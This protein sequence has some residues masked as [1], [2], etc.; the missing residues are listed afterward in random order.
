MIDKIDI[1]FRDENDGFNLVS[2]YDD[3]LEAHPNDPTAR[4]VQYEVAHQ[5]FFDFTPDTMGDA[6]DI[7]RRSR[8]EALRV[9]LDQA[10]EKVGLEAVVDERAKQPRLTSGRTDERNAHGEIPAICMTCGHMEPGEG[11]QF[12]WV[13]CKVWHCDPCVEENPELASDLE[14]WVGPRLALN[15][16]GAGYIDLDRQEA[17]ARAMAHEADLRQKREED[18]RAAAI[19]DA[20]ALKPFE[21]ARRRREMHELR[22]QFPNLAEEADA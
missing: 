16:S 20:E 1:P 8:P 6:M 13:N 15:P 21:E 11:T 5:L 3:L 7:L 17:E 12:R 18:R 10:R 9:Y 4:A 14:P 22:Y 2:I 19:A